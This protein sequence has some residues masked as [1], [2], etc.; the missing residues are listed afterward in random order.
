MT[1]SS[2]R[3]SLDDRVRVA[4]TLAAVVVTVTLPPWWSYGV[5]AAVL[6]TILAVSDVSIRQYLKRYASV[7]PLVL[8]IGALVPFSVPGEPILV[9]WERAGW[10]VT[11]AGLT[12][13][14]LVTTR[15]VL[16]LG[17]LVHMSCSLSPE[18]IISALHGLR[19]P[20]TL[21]TITWLT[22][23]YLWVLLDE[24]RRLTGAWKA[25]RIVSHQRDNLRT[26]IGIAGVLFMRAIER[27]ERV[28][29]AMQERGF[30][31]EFAVAN[32]ERLNG[33]NLAFT[34]SVG[35]LLVGL[36]VLAHTLA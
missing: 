36:S 33:K 15:S 23:R 27:A 1:S 30:T 21:V 20:R 29:I 4:M 11:D 2:N 8:F 26:L 13:W 28:H 10:V 25:R 14:E 3:H 31:G 22:Y 24:T 17:W 18:R 7:M 5:V 12:R 16:A 35:A 6:A 19:V 32:F 34:I 9:V